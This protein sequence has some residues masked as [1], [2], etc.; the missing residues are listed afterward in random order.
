[1]GAIAASIGLTAISFAILGSYDV[2]AIHTVAQGRVAP[3]RSWLAGAASQAFAST[4]AFQA[5][6]ATAVRLRLYRPAGL[7]IADIARV[8]AVATGA[9]ALG[10]A[11]VL[12]MALVLV[13]G[14]AD[15]VLNRAIGIAMLAAMSA[16]VFW[17]GRRPRRFA[18]GVYGV[19]LPSARLTA[20][21]I[22]AG[23]LEMGAAIASLYVLMPDDLVTSYPAFCAGVIGATL[24][25]EFFH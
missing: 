4:L 8:T 20:L 23:A 7:G 25:A 1:M 24:L 10:F 16:L 3:W 11:S 22:V 19:A 9:L 5:I 6:T 17:L 15:P 2:L 12:A 21:V 13:P 14:D 18:L